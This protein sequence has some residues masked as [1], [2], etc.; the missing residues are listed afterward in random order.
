MHVA[1]AILTTGAGAALPGKTGLSRDPAADAS[2]WYKTARDVFRAIFLPGKTDLSRDPA[3]DAFK[4][5]KTARD[6]FR[7]AIFLLVVAG[8][9]YLAATWFWATAAS[10][11]PATSGGSHAHGSSGSTTATLLFQ[12][13]SSALVPTADSILQPIVLRARSQHVLVF[14]TGYAS[15][16]GGA[17]AYNKALSDRRANAVRN[18]LIALGLPAA[19]INP[20]H[21]RRHRRSAPGCLPRRRPAG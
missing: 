9:C 6:V 1:S 16:D 5:Y 8:L 15:P 7:A 21:W 4:R 20:G 11:H 2:K 13:N 17:S 10:G 18:R 14:I 12:F 19:Q 3:A